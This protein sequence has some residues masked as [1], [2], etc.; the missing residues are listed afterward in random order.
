MGRPHRAPVSRRDVRPRAVLGRADA[1]PE[2]RG[3]DRRARAGHPARRRHRR[4]ENN[5]R[6]LH[7]RAFQLLRA[8]IR[9]KRDRKRVPAGLETWEDTPHGEVITRH[10]DVDWMIDRFARGGARLGVRRAGEFTP[11]LHPHPVEAAAPPGPR[12]QR[13]RF[14]NV[15][16]AG[17]RWATSS[18][19]RSS[20]AASAVASLEDGP[21]AWRTSPPITST[22][23]GSSSST[24]GSNTDKRLH[25]T[26]CCGGR[27]ADGGRGPSR[28]STFRIP[29]PPALLPPGACRAHARSVTPACWSG[30]DDVTLLT[31]PQFST[32]AGAFGRLGAPRVSAS[33]AFSR[34][35]C[36]R[37]TRL[38]QP[39]PLRPPRRALAALA[40]RASLARCSSPAS[41]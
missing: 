9:Q 24:P 36:P 15:R 22:S 13:R 5:V 2:R 14:R 19:S 27:P 23:A 34:I 28:W 38:R 31:D 41:A 8:A 39:Q 17:P 4:H 7:T 20:K 30:S 35:A 16:A 40:R 37:S 3:G 25:A 33:R 29:M 12:I 21:Q 10:A 11:N 6:S 1:R 26:C 32:H 18:S